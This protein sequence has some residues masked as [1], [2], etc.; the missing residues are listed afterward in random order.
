M[1]G[2]FEMDSHVR[3]TGDFDVRHITGQCG[4]VIDIGLM[5]MKYNIEFDNKFDSGSDSWWVPMELIESADGL[6][7]SN[8][9]LPTLEY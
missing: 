9:P 1:P 8:D 2:K 4:V 6:Y 5:S 7:L 3:V